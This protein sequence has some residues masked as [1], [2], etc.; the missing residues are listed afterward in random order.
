MNAVKTGILAAILFFVFKLILFFG[1]LQHTILVDFPIA[2]LLITT[3]AGIVYIILKFRKSGKFNVAGAFKEG[4]KVALVSALLSSFI[5]YIYY[6]GIDPDFLEI[7]KIEK[8]KLASTLTDPK[9]LENYKKATEF[10]NSASTRSLFTLSGMT[11]FGLISSLIIALL[12]NTM[13]VNKS[14]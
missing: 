5:V 10:F 12:T 3:F 11:I 7:L 1:N 8:M 13:L 2:P 4:G 6:T 14:R 9:A